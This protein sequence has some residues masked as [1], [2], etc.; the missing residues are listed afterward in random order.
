M[1]S[2]TTLCGRQI[3]S[4]LVQWGDSGSDLYRIE[5]VACLSGT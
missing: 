2:T 3:D 5:L 1:Q 4:V